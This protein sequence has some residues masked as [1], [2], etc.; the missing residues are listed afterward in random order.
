MLRTDIDRHR[1]DMDFIQ[2]ISLIHPER[3]IKLNRAELLIVL[4]KS[5]MDERRRLHGLAETLRR[6]HNVKIDYLQ[7]NTNEFI[8]LLSSND[9][10]P[11]KEMLSDEVCVFSPQAFWTEILDAQQKGLQIRFEGKETDPRRISEQDLTYNLA[12]FGYRE[13]GA[14]VAQ[15]KE[16]SKKLL[17]ASLLLKDNARRMEAVPVILAKGSTDWNLL[18]FL[19]RKYKSAGKL[20]GLTKALHHIRPSKET[21]EAI[22]NMQMMNVKEV[23][24]DKKSI[25]DRLRLYNVIR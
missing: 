1:K 20:L 18:I 7:L 25:E 11:M 16:I 10:N 19:A 22:E 15:A 21:G 4:R 13:F 6:T 5:S 14:A 9:V 23:K 12:Q 24:V 2:S 3:N 17:A 8:G